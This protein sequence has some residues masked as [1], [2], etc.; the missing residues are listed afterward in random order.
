MK[1]VDVENF[2]FIQQ[3]I[4]SEPITGIQLDEMAS[5]VKKQNP[6]KPPYEALFSKVARKYRSMGLN[7]MQ[8]S[9]ND[10]RNY[11]LKEYTFL[12]RPV[13]IINDLI[14]VGNSKK[15]VSAIGETLQQL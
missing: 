1:E 11:I 5:M 6:Q 9:E 14:F 13:F 4:K 3:D 7:E 2:N 15:T 8:L 12:K 10:F